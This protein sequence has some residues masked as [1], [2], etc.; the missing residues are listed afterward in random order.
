MLRAHSIECGRFV[1][2]CVGQFVDR[3]GR[4]VFLDAAEKVIESTSDVA[5]VWL[6]PQMPSEQDQ[7]RIDAYGLGDNFRLVHS[8]TLGKDRLDVLRF[9]R[10]ADAFALPSYVEGLPIALLEAMA[11]ERP[12]I[13]TNVYAIPEAVKHMETG[14]LIE[15]GDSEALADAI[16][17]L[18]NDPTLRAKLGAE[19]RK[20]VLENFDERDAAATAIAAYEEALGRPVNV[21]H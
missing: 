8:A 3:K 19:G 13:S 9:F 16:L 12:S 6:T 7:E 20:F 1:I 21:E 4:W 17:K 18:K 11:L 5:F 10:V 2:L 14:I 15:P